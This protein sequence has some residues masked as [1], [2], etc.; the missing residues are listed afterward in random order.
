MTTTGYGDFTPATAFGRAIAVVAMLVGQIYLVTV[1]AMLVGNLRRR[2]PETTRRDR[3]RRRRGPPAA[4]S[5]P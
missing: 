3:A 4:G 5:R 2:T 1:I